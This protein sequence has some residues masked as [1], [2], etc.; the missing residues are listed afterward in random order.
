MMITHIS[1][2]STSATAALTSA[3]HDP[4]RASAQVPVLKSSETSESA[5]H[6]VNCSGRRERAGFGE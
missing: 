2:N 5:G 1:V 3:S 6:A 4:S